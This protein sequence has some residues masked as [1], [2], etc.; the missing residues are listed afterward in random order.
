[1]RH[2]LRLPSPAFVLALVALLIALG[3]TAFAAA[4]FLRVGSPAGGDLGGTYPNPEIAA[5]AVGSAEVMDGS[6]R[7]V[8]MAIASGVST[9]TE[10]FTLQPGECNGPGR[11]F[12]GLDL[13]AT[14]FVLVTATVREA[15]IFVTGHIDESSPADAVVIDICNFSPSPVTQPPA[16]Y[17]FM[18]IR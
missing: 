8:D 13:E 1:M 4:P 11:G 2:R 14:D 17:R 16:T 5:G 15:G 3:G 7:S 10:S 9:S 6:L 12:N 18:V